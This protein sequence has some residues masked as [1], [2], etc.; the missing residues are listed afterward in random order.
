MHF[1][2]A[3]RLRKGGHGNFRKVAAVSSR[4]GDDGVGERQSLVVAIFPIEFAAVRIAGEQIER[5]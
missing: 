3:V 4:V 5:L 2:H 1:Q